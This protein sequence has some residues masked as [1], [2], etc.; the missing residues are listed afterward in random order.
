MLMND[1]FDAGQLSGDA[2]IAFGHLAA[3]AYFGC[4]IFWLRKLA[5]WGGEQA[6]IEHWQICR[7]GGKRGII[8]LVE[9]LT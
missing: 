4:S 7:G 6:T 9:N 5:A 1:D 2:K 3:D 8:E